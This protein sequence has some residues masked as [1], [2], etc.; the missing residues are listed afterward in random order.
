MSDRFV[1]ETDEERTARRRFLKHAGVLLGAGLAAP[2]AVRAAQQGEL[3]DISRIPVDGL[4][5]LTFNGL[6]IVVLHRSNSTVASLEHN[7]GNLADPNSRQSQQ[8]SF[9]DN[10]YRSENPDWLVM[11]NICT[12]T[13]CRTHYQQNMQ[14]GA[15]G[16]YCYCHGSQ[17][18]AAGRVFSGQPAPWNM[19]IPSYQIDPKRKRLHLISAQRPKIMY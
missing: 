1:K 5:T 3:V 8:P 12:H 2:G 18:D 6:P 9:A 7:Q 17:Y 13:G 14:G 19:E 11:V 4:G 10:P 15:G 16:F